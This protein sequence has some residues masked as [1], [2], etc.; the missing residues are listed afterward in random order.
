[1]GGEPLIIDRFAAHNETL[2]KTQKLKVTVFL[3]ANL[4]PTMTGDHS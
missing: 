1:V 4:V 2:R 3:E